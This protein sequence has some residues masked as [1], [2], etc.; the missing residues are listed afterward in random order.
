MRQKT[1]VA[2]P[3]L[4]DT[5]NYVDKYLTIYVK[6]QAE[7]LLKYGSKEKGS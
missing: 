6:P 5:E 7:V 3:F 4:G 2:Q 1:C